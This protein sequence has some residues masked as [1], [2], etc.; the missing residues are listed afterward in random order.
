MQ[1]QIT[2]RGIY[3]SILTTAGAVLTAVLT[4]AI[5]V[6]VAV[7]I[8]K[9]PINFQVPAASVLIVVGGLALALIYTFRQIEN[10]AYLLAVERNRFEDVQRQVIRNEIVIEVVEKTLMP[11]TPMQKFN[12]E[13]AKHY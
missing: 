4:L 8:W 7:E 11:L 10:Q 3:E 6:Q 1:K 9:L 2:S 12:L 5:L 13:L